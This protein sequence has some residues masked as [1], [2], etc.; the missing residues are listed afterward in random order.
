[1]KVY[2]ESVICVLGEELGVK[3]DVLK[4]YTED[5]KDMLSQ[6]AISSGVTPL[7]MC[8]TR[9]DGEVWTPYIQ[10]I[11]MLIRLG[12]K[13]GFVTYEGRLTATTPITLNM[14]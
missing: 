10:I 4:L 7:M 9:T 1:M 2:R 14:D 5:I 12:K 11:E 8:N 3:K 6:L 13:L